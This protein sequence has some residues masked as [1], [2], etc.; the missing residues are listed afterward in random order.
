MKTWWQNIQYEDFGVDQWE[1]TIL[2]SLKEIGYKGMNW[3]CMVQN[4]DKQQA[5]VNMMSQCS[6]IVFKLTVELVKKI[7]LLE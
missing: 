4:T 3:I 1:D 2:N 7:L 5:M 6:R